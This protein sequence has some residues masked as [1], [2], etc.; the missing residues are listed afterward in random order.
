MNI[1]EE[2]R[3]VDFIKSK[4]SVRRIGVGR[5]IGGMTIEDAFQQ[6]IRHLS[7]DEAEELYNNSMKN[8]ENNN[9]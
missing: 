7:I 5:I 8:Y 9:R 1:I 2:I 4:S 3:M 6:E